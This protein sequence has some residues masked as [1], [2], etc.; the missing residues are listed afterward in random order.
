MCECACVCVRVC[1]C[2]GGCV[3]VWQVQYAHTIVLHNNGFACPS[4]VFQPCACT[5]AAGSGS[6]VDCSQSSISSSWAGAK[7]HAE[8][9]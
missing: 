9:A 7:T 6:E 8:I 1:V 4:K 2:V 3:C 5:V